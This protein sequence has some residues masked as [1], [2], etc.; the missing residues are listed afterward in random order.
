MNRFNVW[1]VYV[2]HVENDE[3][4]EKLFNVLEKYGICEPD[5][6][7]K[8]FIWPSRVYVDVTNMKWGFGYKQLH[9]GYEIQ[10]IDFHNIDKV[11]RL[12]DEEFK[13]VHG[14]IIEIA[15][16]KLLF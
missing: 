12:L 4:A 7:T 1:V 5:T 3:D 9:H 13:D 6:L 16:T 8:S 15:E 10:S 14:A 2:V 11:V